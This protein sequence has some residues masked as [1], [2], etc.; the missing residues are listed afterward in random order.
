MQ[1]VNYVVWDWLDCRERTL[2]FRS[3]ISGFA[4]LDFT[5]FAR[6]PMFAMGR[7]DE[8]D[9][10]SS[11]FMGSF[12]S[13]ELFI[14]PRLDDVIHN[15]RFSDSKYSLFI[16]FQ[17]PLFIIQL[18][19]PKM[20]YQVLAMTPRNIDKKAKDEC[21]LDINNQKLKPTAN[22]RIFGG[23]RSVQIH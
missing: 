19:P 13:Y 8:I 10:S 21:T 9:F 17:T 15:S 14:I 6:I 16:F 3:S 4:A 20:K 1:A 2:T 23:N 7:K 11:V 12:S 5:G 18:P 22:L